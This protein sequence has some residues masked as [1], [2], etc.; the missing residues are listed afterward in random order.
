MP[1]KREFPRNRSKRLRIQMITSESERDSPPYVSDHSWKFLVPRYKK[2]DQLFS[3]KI[4]SS[5]ALPGR[6]KHSD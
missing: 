1:F 2:R 4:S 5:S 6:L 3:R